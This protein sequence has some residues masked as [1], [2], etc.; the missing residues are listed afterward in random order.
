MAEAR[1][2]APQW[3]QAQAA[4]HSEPTAARGSGALRAPA[5]KGLQESDFVPLMRRLTS[6]PDHELYDL[7]DLLGAALDRALPH[8]Q[9]GSPGAL[10][11]GYARTPTTSSAANPACERGGATRVHADKD[12]QGTV[13]LRELFVVLALVAAGDR[14]QQ[15]QA[16]YLLG[17]DLYHLTVGFRQGWQA[18][19]LWGLLLDI[20]DSVLWET[21]VALEVPL[22]ATLT[23]QDFQMLFFA[24][25]QGAPAS[26]PSARHSSGGARRRDEALEQ[27]A[28]V[29]AQS[30]P[31][32]SPCLI[33]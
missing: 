19:R 4:V 13:G 14:K 18:M 15:L 33:A 17:H 25:L 1:A 28:P 6:L 20:K 31:P 9:S 24:T 21:R 12:A 22:G 30:G 7:M 3:F 11:F 32:R 29:A 16:I 8:P 5:S 23:F 2:S 26:A 10:G 27:T